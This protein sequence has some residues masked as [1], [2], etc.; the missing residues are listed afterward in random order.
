MTSGNW[1]WY[2]ISNT[3][4]K[5]DLSNILNLSG[6]CSSAL[7]CFSLLTLIRDVVL[8]HVGATFLEYVVLPNLIFFNPW[9]ILSECSCLFFDGLLEPCS[10]RRQVS[11]HHGYFRMALPPMSSSISSRIWFAT[12]LSFWFV[13]CCLSAWHNSS[14]WKRWYQTCAG[15]CWQ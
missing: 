13:D 12:L 15:E 10:W 7:N 9:H 3:F 2:L 4:L 8:V 14:N 5:I 1:S 11:T 6:I